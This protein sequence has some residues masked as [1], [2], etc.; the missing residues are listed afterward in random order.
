MDP[1]PDFGPQPDWAVGPHPFHTSHALQYYRGASWCWHCAAVCTGAP[2]NLLEPCP[3]RGHTAGV[4]SGPERQR[5]YTLNR[6]RKR[7]FPRPG[8][9]WPLPE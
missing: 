4:V 9:D 2:R 1:A 6:L 7:L 3:G 8:Q 5:R